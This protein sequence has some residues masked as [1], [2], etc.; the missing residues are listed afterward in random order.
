[1]QETNQNKKLQ[2]GT[3]LCGIVYGLV[4]VVI[5][6]C[7]LYLGFWKTLLIVAFF[8]IGYVIGA[9]NNKKAFVEAA[10]STVANKQD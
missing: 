6:L 3:P 9:F 8:A 2:V 7:L 4:G 5:A 1:M 10:I